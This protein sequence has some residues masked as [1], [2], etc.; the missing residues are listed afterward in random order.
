[1]DLA[2]QYGSGYV[3]S[4]VEYGECLAAPLATLG[5]RIADVWP[6]HIASNVQYVGTWQHRGLV[7]VDGSVVL[8]ESARDLALA[9]AR[10][11]GQT[12]IY[13]IR[14]A[15]AEMVADADD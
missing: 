6:K 7:F 15:S 11:H 4:V 14:T 13:N 2:R 5:E 1:M 3:V 12:A 9:L 8:P 10:K